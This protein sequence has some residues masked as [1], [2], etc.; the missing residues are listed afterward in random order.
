[1]R[2][3]S[4][5]EATVKEVLNKKFIEESHVQKLIAIEEHLQAIKGMIKYDSVKAF[6]MCLSSDTTIL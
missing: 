4:T 6:E 1:V 3:D 5:L 2:F